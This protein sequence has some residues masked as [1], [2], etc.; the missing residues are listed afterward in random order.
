M[1]REVRALNQALS[2]NG[3]TPGRRTR[4]AGLSATTFDGD[5]DLVFAQPQ[6][7]KPLDCS[8]VLKRFQ[9]PATT[10]R[11]RPSASTTSAYL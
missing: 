8:K 6:T 5:L 11:Y 4:P 3:Q 2:T 10:P 7:G 1:T 9:A